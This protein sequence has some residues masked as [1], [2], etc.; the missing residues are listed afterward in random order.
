MFSR[1][2]WLLAAAVS[3]TFGLWYATR[4][5]EVV[6]AERHLDDG[7]V[8][9]SSVFCGNAPAMV[10]TGTY[11]EDVRGPATQADCLRSGRTKVA[12]VIGLFLIGGGMV[13]GGFRFGK[14]PPRPLRSEL[15]ELPGGER[16]VRGKS[17]SPEGSP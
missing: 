9:V 1:K 16:E 11:D 10:F 4:P 14:E 7:T 8:Y 3:V 5:V 13:Y 17:R 12:E 6:Y 2:I 15:P